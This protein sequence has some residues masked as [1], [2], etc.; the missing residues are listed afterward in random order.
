[1]INYK[2][3]EPLTVDIVNRLTKLYPSSKICIILDNTRKQSPKLI[4]EIIKKCPE[5]SNVLISVTGGL[6]PKKKKFNDADYRQRTIYTLMELSKII[7]YFQSIERCI[8]ISWTESQKA[9][10]VYQQI[11]NSMEYSECYMDDQDNARSLTGVLYGKAVCSGFALILKEA[12][13]R[14]GIS[15]E[16]QNRQ[17]HHSWNIAY[18]DGAYRALE[19]TW[20][21]YNK[22]EYGCAFY[23][24]NRDKDFYNNPHHNIK[25][26]KEEIEFPITPY[27]DQELVSNCEIICK[28]KILSFDVDNKNLVQTKIND[29]PVTFQVYDDNLYLEGLPSKRFVRADGSSFLLVNDG[30]YK[31][32]NKILYFE[33]LNNTIRG[34]VLYSEIKLDNLLDKYDEVIAN[35]LLSP[36]RLKVKIN[37]FNG[38]VGFV[39]KDYSVYYDKEQEENLNIIR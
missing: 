24:F 25:N 9:M 4:E 5:S 22:K 34:T 37:E 23:Y 27:T 28:P 17:G 29:V 30:V 2:I 14:L 36:E 39:G 31:D 26:E 21:C 1:M 6:N 20:D 8:D 12:L 33:K 32:L 15:N 19:L 11:C 3:D 35:N 18:L 7:K 10:Y 16:Y 13:D 38:Y